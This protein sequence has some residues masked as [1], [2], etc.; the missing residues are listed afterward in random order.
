MA[1]RLV[2]PDGVLCERMPIQTLLPV[3]KPWVSKAMAD[4]IATFP[5]QNQ[6]VKRTAMSVLWFGVLR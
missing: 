3:T 2:L 6:Q 4:R 1:L 5:I